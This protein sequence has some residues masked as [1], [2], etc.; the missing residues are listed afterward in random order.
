MKVYK[1]CLWYFMFEVL[2]S[3]IM[4][5]SIQGISNENYRVEKIIGIIATVNVFTYYFCLHRMKI[6]VFS[7]DSYFILFMYLFNLG[8]PIARAFG[9][10]R[11]NYAKNFI[12]SRIYAL[13]ENNF[14]SY[15]LFVFNLISMIQVGVIYYNIK[16]RMS[17]RRTTRLQ[18]VDNDNKDI[19]TCKKLGW[20]LIACGIIPFIY[21]EMIY[22]RQARLYGYQ[23]A[24]SS[25]NLSGTGLGLIGNLVTIGVFYLLVYYRSKRKT[26]NIISILFGGYH[27]LRMAITGDRSTGLTIIL[28]LILMRHKYIKPIKIKD[29]IPVACIAY[30]SLLFIKL[31]E[32]TRSMNS[33]NLTELILELVEDNPITETI[34]E[35][36]GNVW[37]GLMVYYTVPSVGFFRLGLTYIASIVGKPLSILK[38]TNSIWE[39]GDYSNF[40]N[41]PY[42]SALIAN[43]RRAMGGS[44]SGEVW[45]NFGWFGILVM[46]LFGFYLAKFSDSCFDDRH[47][48]IMTG[49]LLYVATL[50]IWWVRQYFT[51][52]AWYALFYA[53]F[54]TTVIYIMKIKKGG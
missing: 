49:Y 5:S 53:A 41:K 52:V 23:N 45:F 38:I 1:K 48:P 25:L 35:Y 37:S 51:S 15:M 18:K 12:E 39:F 19:Y 42:Q 2:L 8:L 28:I 33:Y 16:K 44:F 36:G 26:F 9:W 11:T 14:L 4:L 13:G 54:I 30:A 31:I 6:D 21:S 43:V 17:S 47:S 32:I 20:L 40:L 22:F 24:D 27:I 46:P 7:V 34:V 50:I 3:L 29:F 10:I